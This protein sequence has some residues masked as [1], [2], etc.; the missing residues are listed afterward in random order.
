MNP[1]YQR[2]D[3]LTAH[4]SGTGASHQLT[5]RACHHCDLLDSRTC[6]LR[7]LRTLVYSDLAQGDVDF[8]RGADGARLPRGEAA[9]DVGRVGKGVSDCLCLAEQVVLAFHASFAP[10]LSAVE[11]EAREPIER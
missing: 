2:A 3:Q 4:L 7:P 11:I 9:H 1:A 5:V 6:H 8:L 10:S